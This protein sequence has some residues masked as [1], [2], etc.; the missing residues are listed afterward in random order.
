MMGKSSY[1]SD[2]VLWAQEQ[3][4][5][6]RA[7]EFA[8][9]DLEHLADEIEDVGKSEKR[10]LASRVTVLLVHLLKWQH[11]P[12]RR[13]ASW[14]ITIAHQRKRIALAIEETP[15][16]KSVLRDG[17]WLDAVWLDAVA[18]AAKETRLSELRFD[19]T[20]PWPMDDVLTHIGTE[21]EPA[22]S[23]G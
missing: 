7:G 17:K 19:E 13:G 5:L 20:C 22:N 21:T 3:A 16:L 11:Q 2:V 9:L 6:L 4:A 18:Q 8:Q 1:N 23:R 12:K 10:E 15:S 14:Q